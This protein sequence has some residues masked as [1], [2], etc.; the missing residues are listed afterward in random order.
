[1]FSLLVFSCDEAPTNAW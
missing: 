1:V